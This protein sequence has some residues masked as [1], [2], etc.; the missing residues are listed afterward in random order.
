MYDPL[1]SPYEEWLYFFERKGVSI[2]YEKIAKK[3]GEIERSREK[4]AQTRSEVSPHDR[5]KDK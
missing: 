3:K 2:N 5:Q 4:R 1:R